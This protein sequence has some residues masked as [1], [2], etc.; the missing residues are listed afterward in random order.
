VKPDSNNSDSP[1]DP[2]S[3]SVFLPA[4]QLLATLASVEPKLEAL[5]AVDRD[6]LKHEH[7]FYDDTPEALKSQR[8]AWRRVEAGIWRLSRDLIALGHAHRC[9]VLDGISP[10]DADFVRDILGLTKEANL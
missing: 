1:R 4:S 6:N 2:L 9:R 7:W 8:Q 3:W 10:E 5:C